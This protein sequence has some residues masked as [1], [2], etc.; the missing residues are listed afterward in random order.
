MEKV[1]R[2]GAL[3]RSTDPLLTEN[4]HLSAKKRLPRTFRES[5][6]ISRMSEEANQL[7]RMPALFV[8]CFTISESREV[9]ESHGIPKF[10]P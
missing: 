1:Q 2:E 7:R 10:T 3:P 9:R 6:S 4:C 8:L 5:S